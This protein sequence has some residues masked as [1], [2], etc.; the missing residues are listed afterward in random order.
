[1]ELIIMSAKFHFL[2]VG[3]GDCTIVH[4]PER[5]TTDAQGN[6]RIKA[7]R[8][9]M[10]DIYHREDHDEFENII[11]YYKKHFTDESGRIKP[12]FRFVCTHPHQDHICGLAE[13]FENSG[14]QIINFWDVEHEFEP[15]EYDKLSSHESDWKTY[16]EKR[17]SAENPTIIRTTREATPS[18][19]WNDDEDRIV[20]LS[21]SKE[22]L[23][24]AHY[25]EDASKREKHLVEIDEISYAL[26]I[27]INERKVVLSGDGRS[28]PVWDD[29][30]AN[31]KEH[32][33]GCNILKAAHHGQE[34]GFHEDAVKLMSP[35]IVI[36]SNSEEEDKK[37]GAE[38]L[39][40]KAAPNALLF[41]TSDKGNIIISVPYDSNKAIKYQTEN[42]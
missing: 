28:N 22:L 9:M 10:V 2:N 4:F 32:I 12:I 34:S 6:K 39:Y 38:D 13:L 7:E 41:K 37:H 5:T 20:I 16:S 35:Q 3:S 18:Q 19:Y 11:E 30:Y 27:K 29:I 31:C 42:E 15:E 23:R 40:K 17:K 24:R 21:P 25:G 33:K 36:F 14:I 8:I 1:M 26:M